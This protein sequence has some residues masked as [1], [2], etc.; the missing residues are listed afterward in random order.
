MTKT[1]QPLLLE[2]FPANPFLRQAKDKEQ[3]MTV[4][5]GLKCLE[6]STKYIQPG[7]LVKM[8]LVSSVWK[9]AK[10]LK[11]YSLTWKMKRIRWKYLLYQ[12]VPSGHGTEGIEFGLLPTPVAQEGPGMD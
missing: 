10:H 5:S 11:G 7:L 9:M 4:I 6:L 2:D 1:S 8:L 3:R 12:L